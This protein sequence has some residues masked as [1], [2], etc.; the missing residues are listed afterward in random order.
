[1]A[2]AIGLFGLAAFVA[3]LFWGVRL[4][5]RY[6]LAVPACVVEDIKARAAIKRSVFLSKGSVGKILAIY[7]LVLVINLVVAFGVAIPIQMAL[8][9]AKTTL[10]KTMMTV[11]QEI[12][13]FVVGS[14]VG[15]LVTIALSLVYFDERVR[16]EAFDIQ[17]MMQFL[18]QA[19]A[20]AAAAPVADIPA[21]VAEPLTAPDVQPETAAPAEPRAEGAGTTNS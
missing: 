1:M 2:V 20:Q 6:S 11:L 10:I 21:P 18:P 15:P 12:G 14:V 9:A 17:Y 19:P 13:S 4:F 7:V 5:A 3:A 16:K 8:F